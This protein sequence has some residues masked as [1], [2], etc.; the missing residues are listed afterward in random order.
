M[1]EFVKSLEA[2]GLYFLQN[3]ESGFRYQNVLFYGDSSSPNSGDG[4]FQYSVSEQG[5]EIWSCV[6]DDVDVLITHTPAQGILD[7]DAFGQHIGCAELKKAL[8]SRLRPVLHVC[9]HVHPSAGSLKSETG[10]N[11]LLT[12]NAAYKLKQQM[13]SVCALQAR[14]IS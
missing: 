8:E 10:S 13:A 14:S 11:R 2:D 4:A 7:M 6:P 12:V 5:E 3:Y 9:G 1:M